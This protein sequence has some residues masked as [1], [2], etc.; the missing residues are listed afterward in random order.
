MSGFDGRVLSQYNEH[1]LHLTGPQKRQTNVENLLN[2][3]HKYLARNS[4]QAP[5]NS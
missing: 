5:Y 1:D 4:F 3:A 2:Y